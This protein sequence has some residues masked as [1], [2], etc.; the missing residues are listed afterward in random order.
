MFTRTQ[1]S[2][3]S[4]P[5][6]AT[7]RPSAAVTPGSTTSRDLRPSKSPLGSGLWGSAGAAGKSAL[8]IL[9]AAL[10][11][12]SLRGA[13]DPATLLA[14]ASLQAPQG[15]SQHLSVAL[16]EVLSCFAT[17]VR[18]SSAFGRV[19][20]A[21]FEPV[22][23][24]SAGRIRPITIAAAYCVLVLCTCLS[25]APSIR[26][27]R[28]FC[29]DS[30]VTLLHA[31]FAP[32]G[33]KAALS[34]CVD[35]HP[36][37]SCARH[38]LCPIVAGYAVRAGDPRA[39]GVDKSRALSH[40]CPPQLTREHTC[41]WGSSQRAGRASLHSTR[42][43]ALQRPPRRRLATWQGRRCSGAVEHR[44]VVGTLQPCRLPH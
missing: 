6:L 40:Q 26:R 39:A 29:P 22:C 12:F 24:R 43:A 15:A 18:G 17:S 11:A 34:R 42:V 30:W 21:C 23:A 13:V 7:Q 28:R 14:E 19:Y 27:S 4:S 31:P 16:C 25:L 35:D 3:S 33:G 8:L 1:R 9:F 37:E 10:V 5:L 32:R 44:A 41:R 38:V 20:S 36:R 2:R